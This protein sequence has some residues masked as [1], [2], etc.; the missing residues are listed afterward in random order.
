MNAKGSEIP[1]EIDNI[2]QR[3]QLSRQNR[4]QIAPKVIELV[5]NDANNLFVKIS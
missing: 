3:T 5:N 4:N 2:C 1:F